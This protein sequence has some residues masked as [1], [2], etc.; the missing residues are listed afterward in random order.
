MLG[1]ANFNQSSSEHSPNGVQKKPTMEAAQ[2]LTKCLGLT[3][4]T[5]EL[6]YLAH[7]RHERDKMKTRFKVIGVLGFETFAG[8][9]F[10]AKL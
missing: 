4:Q 1:I 2:K 5:I 10:R 7:R 3:L 6:P 9:R 8:A